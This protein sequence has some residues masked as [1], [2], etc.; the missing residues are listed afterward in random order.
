MADPRTGTAATAP[1]L[2]ARVIGRDRELGALRAAL[3]EARAGRGSVVFLA[4]EAGIGKSR[5]AHEAATVARSRGMVLLRGRAV[6]A[7]SPVAYRP[8]A[9]A[10]CSP[11]RAGELPDT[12]ELAPFRA[13]LG[14]LI[15][16]WREERGGS[17]DDSVVLLGEAVLR[18]LRAVAGGDGGLMI[19]EDL[20][21]ADPETVQVVEY[22]ADN[23][24]SEPVLCVGTLRVEDKT[25]ALDLA[26]TLQ[27]RRVS[28]V[29]DL[30]RL[31][32][33]AVAEMVR[34]CLGCTD[35]PNEIVGLASRAEGVPFLV[36]EILAT[37]VAAGALVDE[38]G[39][40]VVGTGA[41]VVP[42]TFADS[43]RRRL[44]TLGDNARSVL[45][46]AAVLGRRF[47]WALIS[48]ITGLGEPEVLAALRAA[49]DAQVVATEDDGAA[50]RF[51]HALTRDAVLGDL[52]PPERAALSARVLDVIEAEH[53]GLPGEWCELAAEMAETAGRREDAAL[54]LL[55][56]GR[57]ALGRGALV[58]A[59]TTLDRARRRAPVDSATILDI[60]ECLNEVLSLAGKRDRVV[61]VAGSLLARLGGAPELA[62]RRAE[63]QLRLA[64]AAVAAT[65]WSD[66]HQPLNAARAYAE[67]AGDE[68]LTARA[69]ALGAHLAM[70]E[71]HPENASRL[72][73]TALDTA[74]RVDLPEVACEALEIIGRCERPVDLDAAEAAFARAHTVAD[75][76]GLTVWRVRALHELGTIDL[77]RRGGLERLE[78]A[79]KLAVS[80]GALAT[81]AVLDVQ[82]AAA[83]MVRDD[84]EPVLSIARRS[85]DL[86]RRLHLDL[87]YAAARAFEA[88][89]HARARR[90]SAMEECI[91]DA[92][93][94][95][96][97]D[98]SIVMATIVQRV[99][100]ALVEEDRSRAIP[101]LDEAMRL[102]REPRGDQ[103]SGPTPGLWALTRVIDPA[104]EAAAVEEAGEPVHFWAWAYLRYA[105]AVVLGRA[106]REDEA[107]TMMDSGDERLAGFEW[108]R[109]YG[110]RLVAEAAIEDGWGAP[111]AWL[112]E[113][114]AFF[115]ERGDDAIASACR[116]LLRRAGA[117]VP[118]QRTGVGD[119]PGPLRALGVT[120]REL[121]VIRLLADGMSNKDIAARLYLSP[122][123]VERHVS[124][125]TAKAGVEGRSPLVAWAA[126]ST[127]ES[128]TA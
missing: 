117:S 17:L 73:R 108:L 52:L 69:D 15:P 80:A 87:T 97:G 84:V 14:R 91:A 128:R 110:R 49:V 82:I 123:T 37:S 89:A 96:G 125:L 4:G 34:D 75:E 61:E 67:E 32:E 101:D 63:V 116:S 68:G 121:E 19:L 99:I 59:E 40:W 43:V 18:F 41:P 62:P 56:A 100:C 25:P 76:H 38:G 10:L 42:L 54:L 45:A 103:A 109:L 106:G 13:V 24:R 93:V 29:L 95:A 22:L 77:L 114:L 92:L 98:P 88:A 127:G 46:A 102:A 2:C 71:Q 9:E 1:V 81:V 58:T 119:V 94:H 60:E 126:R 79:R 112:R 28:E 6:Q 65:R 122:R 124:N 115:S 105:E 39:A 83:H 64:R 118:R 33:P 57:R 120:A 30:S 31:G 50:F 86:A 44:G 20:H 7:A 55:E 26:R 3:D 66:A 51:R 47:D 90:R 85:A 53:P 5:L 27:S 21:W 111:E 12:P 107:A 8:L 74:E 35:L 11:G 36:E 113:A 16:E 70:G 104:T 78:E 23:L 48:P 72:A